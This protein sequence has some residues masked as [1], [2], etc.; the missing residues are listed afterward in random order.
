MRKFIRFLF[1]LMATP[2]I[3]FVMMP[4]FYILDCLFDGDDASKELFI[5]WFSWVTFRQA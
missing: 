5:G 2:F 3:L 1:A 4:A